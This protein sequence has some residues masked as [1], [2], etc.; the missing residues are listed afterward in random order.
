MEGEEKLKISCRRVD[1]TNGLHCYMVT[2][3]EAKAAWSKRSQLL[4]SSTLNDSAGLGVVLSHSEIPVDSQGKPCAGP[5]TRCKACGAR[6]VDWRRVHQQNLGDIRY[7]FNMLKTEWI[8]HH[9]WH[10]PLDVVTTKYAYKKGLARLRERVQTR[11][12]KAIGCTKASELWRDGRQTPFAGKPHR[13]NVIYSAQ[14][15][16]ATCCRKCVE[17]WHKIPMDRALTEEEETYLSA[18]A[19]R[20]VTDRLPDLLENGGAVPS[21]S[22]NNVAGAEAPSTQITDFS[23]VPV[24][25]VRGDRHSRR[26]PGNGAQRRPT[27]R[28]RS[29]KRRSL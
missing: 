7:T 4:L 29:A 18:L 5:L 28:N 24:L 27:N 26:L 19:M 8:R 12:H 20:F 6:L 9:F 14:H 10:E 16:T 21:T 17:L 11:I 13:L 15:A 2:A 1:C 3:G 22:V 25:E 23:P